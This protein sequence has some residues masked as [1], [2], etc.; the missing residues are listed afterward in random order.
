MRLSVLRDGFIIAA[1]AVVFAI[2][3][4]AIR[5]DGIPLLAKEEFDIYVP[6]TESTGEAVSVNPSTP[7]IS[8]PSSL[9]IDAR[10]PSAYARKHLPGA[11]SQPFDWLAEQDEVN[12]RANQIARR[13]ASSGKHHV[14]VYGDGGN[15]DSG[16]H[17]AALLS[18]SGIRNVVY[19][20]GGAEAL[21]LADPGIGGAE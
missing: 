4:N 13:I 18:A 6:C 14:V 2:A 17:W 12:D 16:K 11:V 3:V 10:S 5:P 9:I 21:Q 20:T 15:P 1:L 8:D 7:L 19:V